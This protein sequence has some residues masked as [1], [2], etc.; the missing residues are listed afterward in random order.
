MRFVF[1]TDASIEVGTGHVMRCLTLANALAK[2]GADGAECHFICRAHPGNLI[3][4]IRKKGYQV[5]SLP[6]ISEPNEGGP[7]GQFVH[8]DW[9][10]SSSND[11]AN[12]CAEILQEI[13]PDWLIVDHYALDVRWEK[14]LTPYFRKLM[15]ID[16]LA[17]REHC[18]DLLLDQTFGRNTSDYLPW[19]PETSVRLCGAQYALLRPEFERWRERSLERRKAG[20]LEHILINL[21]GVDKGNITSQ[22]LIALKACEIP[23][24]TCVTVVMGSTAPWVDDVSALAAEMPWPT[25]VK[26]GVSNMAE[27]MASSDLAIGAAGA[28][29]WERC[30]L[31]LPSF[32]IMLAK[33]QEKV[34]KELECAGAAIC[35]DSPSTIK[36]KLSASVESL[37][38]NPDALRNMSMRASAVTDG[39]GAALVCKRMRCLSV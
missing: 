30:S 10:G 13:K 18:C 15:V 34:A 36:A 29:S 26:V 14:A 33:N 5:Y 1:R 35:I 27:F 23:K 37:V 9:L 11:D 28:T 22:V 6:L 17:D 19:T 25:V 39:R 38:S 12:A 8:A 20:K 32:L 24:K 16:D 3:E 21:G 2:H 4:F 31:G 7:A